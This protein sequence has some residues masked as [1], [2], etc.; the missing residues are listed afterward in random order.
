MNDDSGFFPHKRQ[1]MGSLRARPT[2]SNQPSMPS[3]NTAVKNDLPPSL[4]IGKVLQ[5]S[6]LNE[7]T[8]YK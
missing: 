4:D 6:L 8:T 1:S 3:L 5:M 2:P 7:M